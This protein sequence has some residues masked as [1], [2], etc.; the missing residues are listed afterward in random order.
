MKAFN[1]MVRVATAGLFIA[2][3]GSVVAQQAYPSKPIRFITPYPPGGSTTVLARLIGQELIESWGQPVIVDNRPGGNTIIGTEALVKSAPDGHT[4][5]LTSTSHVVT[6]L[7]LSTPF[8]AIKDF[9]PIAT[10]SSNETILVVHPSLPINN[11]PEFI[12]L[13]KTKPGQLNYASVGSG[14]VQHLTVELFSILAGVKLQHIPYKG[15]AP[16]VTDLIAGQVQ[17]ALVPPFSVLPHIK[18]G[19][20]RPIAITGETRASALPDVPT[21]TEAGLRDFDGRIWF[22]VLAPARTPNAI[23]DKLSAEIMRIMS[24]SDVKQKLLSVGMDTFVSGPGQF[25]ALMKAD[26]AKFAMVIKTANIKLEN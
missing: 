16:A 5:L 4:I 14:G 19:R 9:S 7:V 18:S 22:G 10:T 3:A 1:A 2:L 15:S 20:I 11:L 21:F 26:T 8:D 13:A 25:A 6:A 23:I 12:A 17:L 24:M